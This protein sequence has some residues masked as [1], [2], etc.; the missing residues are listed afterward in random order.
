MHSCTHTSR[1]TQPAT[2]ILVHM[3]HHIRATTQEQTLTLRKFAL[4]TPQTLITQLIT[5]TTH[6]RSSPL[7]G[8]SPEDEVV[9]LESVHKAGR[10]LCG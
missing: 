1:V 9:L 3:H 8:A 6:T 7:G 10:V 4:H 2:I 5:H